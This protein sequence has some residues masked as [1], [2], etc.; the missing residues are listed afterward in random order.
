MFIVVQTQGGDVVIGLDEPDDFSRFD[1]QILDVSEDEARKSLERIAVL[2]SEH[3]FV[4]PAALFS[5]PGARPENADW[6]NQFELMTDYAR[7][8][9]WV[10]ESGRIRA[11]V[12]RT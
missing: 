2:Q 8:K 6:V 12:V 11:H 5:L 10:D 7:S 3:A 9:G 1:I 4:D